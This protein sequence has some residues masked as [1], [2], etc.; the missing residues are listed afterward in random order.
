MSKHLASVLADHLEIKNNEAS[1]LGWMQSSPWVFCNSYGTP[2]DPNNLRRRVFYKAI[3]AA[4]LKKF[5]IHDL[6]H[7]FATLLI[8]NGESLAV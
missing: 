7:T 4:G 2:L 8:E 5:R 3:E 6:R 1:K